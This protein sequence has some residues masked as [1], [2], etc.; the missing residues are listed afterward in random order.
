MFSTLS[1]LTL[2]HNIHISL[3]L[4]IYLRYKGQESIKRLVNSKWDID[5][6][7]TEQYG[8]QYTRGK[9]TPLEIWGMKLYRVFK[10]I[11]TL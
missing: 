3:R 5:R 11:L 8:Q 9:S 1:A 2:V 7:H 10:E 4:V 6:G